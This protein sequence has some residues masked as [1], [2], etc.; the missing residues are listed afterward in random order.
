[1]RTMERP[2]KSEQAPLVVIVDD[3]ASLRISARMLVASFGFRAEVFP[4]AQDFLT[5]P[6]HETTS[7]LILDV[8]MPDMNGLE[9][10]RRLKRSCP[11]LPIIFLTA[12][13]KE[14]EERQA[15]R[16][17]AV[18]MLRKPVAEDVL[19]RA[20]RFALSSEDSPDARQDCSV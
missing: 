16:T 17:G 6:E 8:L 9:L 14:H 3:D 12:H 20:L 5:W 15:L 18:A 11:H 19:L 7:C 2:L 1:V 4:S 13:A 10:Q